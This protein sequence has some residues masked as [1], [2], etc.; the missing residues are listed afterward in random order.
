[1][2]APRRVFLSHTSELRDHPENRSFV[3]AAEE[4]VMAAGDA[5]IDMEYFSAR[6][7]KPAAYCQEKIQAC[8]VYVGIIGF[9]YGSPVKDQAN[10]SYTQLEFLTAKAANKPLLIFL[11]HEDATNVPASAL[12][13]RDYG[14]RQDTFRTSLH[15]EE[16]LTVAFFKSPDELKHLLY[17]ALN[18]PSPPLPPPVSPPKA[19]RPPH[20]RQSRA[21]PS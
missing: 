13:D 15:S 9:R 14:E 10:V 20:G 6:S 12:I 1:M 21:G 19:S 5:V 7:Q 8:D 3:D 17:Q 11:L 4:A 18:E 16:G 2:A